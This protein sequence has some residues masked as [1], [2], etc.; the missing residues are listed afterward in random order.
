M[1]VRPR[2]RT[3]PIVVLTSSNEE[4]DLAECYQLG[5]DSY[6]REPVNFDRFVEA[7]R[8]LGLYGMV[9]NEPPPR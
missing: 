7:A 5:C 3:L 8:Q 9:L 6:V 1:R 2:T 4:R